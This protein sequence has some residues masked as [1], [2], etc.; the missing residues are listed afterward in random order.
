MSSTIRISIGRSGTDRSRLERIKSRSSTPVCYW[1]K[2][3]NVLSDDARASDACGCECLRDRASD[4]S[5]MLTIGASFSLTI[6]LMFGLNGSK[7]SPRLLPHPPVAWHTCNGSAVVAERA[8][9][10]VGR[11]PYG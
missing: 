7:Q 1:L 5:G 6:I 10:Q 9:S 11:W 3:R 4:F 8:W 2:F